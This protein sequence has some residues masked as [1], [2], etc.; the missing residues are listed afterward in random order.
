MRFGAGMVGRRKAAPPPSWSLPAAPF[1]I[2]QPHRGMLLLPYGSQGL[3]SAVC[4]DVSHVPTVALQILVIRCS[5][6]PLSA[7]AQE[8]HFPVF[9]LRSIGRRCIF[10]LLTVIICL[11]KFI[12]CI[13]DV[14]E[15]RD[16]KKHIV[17]HCEMGQF[18]KC[19]EPI[20]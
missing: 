7:L 4:Y 16:L 6:L 9:V 8:T 19:L 13:I 17:E 11:I 15:T 18:S 12:V 3:I 14:F 2:T 20:A 10:S 1:L 5:S